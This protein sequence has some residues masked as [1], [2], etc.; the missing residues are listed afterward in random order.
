MIV[1]CENYFVPSLRT[2]SPVFQTM[3]FFSS[4]TLHLLDAITGELRVVKK[5][6]YLIGSSRRCDWRVAEA[7]MPAEAALFDLSGKLHLLKSLASGSVY[8]NRAPLE[9]Q[10]YELE[11]NHDYG[12]QI[13]SR[14]LIARVSKNGEEWAR[15]IDLQHWIAFS[16]KTGTVIGTFTPETLWNFLATKSPGELAVQDIVVTP[17]GTSTTGFPTNLLFGELPVPAVQPEINMP[18]ELLPQSQQRPQQE[19]PVGTPT[20]PT[21]TLSGDELLCPTCWLRFGAGDVMSIAVHDNLRGDAILGAD[22]KLRFIPTAFNE[23]GQALDS[24]GIPCIDSACPHCRRKL[25]PSFLEMPANIISLVGAPSAGKSYYLCT[26]IKTL[27]QVLF[28][29]FSLLFRDGDP[30]GNAHLNEMKNQLF[31]AQAPEQAFILKTDF[32]GIMY[33]RF[34]RHGKMVALPRPFVYEIAPTTVP[35]EIASVIFYDNAG[36][37][38]KPNVS[39]DDSPGALHVASSA[40]I[41]FLIDPTSHPQFRARLRDHHD[42]QLTLNIADG[43]DAILAEM[44]VRIR[45]ISGHGIHT[46]VDT[47]LAIILGKC[48]VWE[49]LLPGEPLIRPVRNGRLDLA[50]L[51]DNSARIRDLL[52]EIDPALVAIAESISNRV[53]FFPV[54]SF[55][56]SPV[57]IKDGPNTGKLAPDPTKLTPRMVEI[58]MLWV[59]SLIAPNWV[60][61]I[62][63]RQNPVNY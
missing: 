32:E 52:L 20:E 17:K 16:G 14:L 3:S 34:P 51:N 6:P 2:R 23:H 24:M 37:H 19:P 4:A 28:K 48:D 63:P 38:F 18:P 62:A 59:L 10:T 56:H 27:S 53:Q 15:K 12:L 42:P 57:P 13:G 8:I 39:L 9:R 54:S 11:P 43:Q 25:P 22:A 36:E 60:P 5:F 7:G 45:A 1:T 46:R 29:E 41:L 21:N 61:S 58:P 40:G 44:G 31:S 26:L 33:E 50:R 49:H 30:S 47:P 55:G 35:E